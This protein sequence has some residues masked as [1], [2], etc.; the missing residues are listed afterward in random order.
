VAAEV[1]VVVFA[2]ALSAP[3]AAAAPVCEDGVAVCKVSVV[4]IYNIIYDLP[5]KHTIQIN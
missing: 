2:A 5:R 1:A 3:V 4:N